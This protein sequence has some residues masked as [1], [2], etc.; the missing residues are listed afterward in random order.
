VYV[1]YKNKNSLFYYYPDKETTL[2][3]LPDEPMAMFIFGNDG[4]IA[5]VDPQFLNSF[6]VKDHANKKVVFNMKKLPKKPL[7]KS[8]LAALTGL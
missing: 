3:L 1:V 4:T 5:S 2:K 6:D 7:D 8:E